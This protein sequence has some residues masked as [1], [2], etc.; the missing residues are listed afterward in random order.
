[1]KTLQQ[2][3]TEAEA[4]AKAKA[5]ANN[6]IDL[7]IKKGDVQSSELA[8]ATVVGH[9]KAMSFFEKNKIS[10]L[11]S[12]DFDV[13]IVNDKL[14]VVLTKEGMSKIKV[15]SKTNKTYLDDVTKTLRQAYKEYFSK[16]N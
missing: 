1:M 9:I 2:I 4:K 14:V 5:K 16:I 12:G 13:K 15:R 6:I 10:P 8:R 11:T 3:I 7:K